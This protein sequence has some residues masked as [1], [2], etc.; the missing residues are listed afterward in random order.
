MQHI[1]PYDF[2]SLKGLHSERMILKLT[3]GEGKF[4]EDIC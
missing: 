2:V 3:E 1:Q 4:K